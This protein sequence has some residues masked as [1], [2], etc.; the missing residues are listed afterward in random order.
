MK[1]ATKRKL[2][3]KERFEGSFEVQKKKKKKKKRRRESSDDVIFL[4]SY[5]AE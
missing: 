1:K 4:R 3:A 2:V 5:T